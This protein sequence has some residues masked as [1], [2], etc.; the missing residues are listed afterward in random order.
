MEFVDRQYAKNTGYKHYW[1][2]DFIF[3]LCYKNF[4]DQVDLDEHWQLREVI[5]KVNRFVQEPVTEFLCKHYVKNLL[6]CFYPFLSKKIKFLPNWGLWWAQEN[7]LIYNKKYK[8]YIIDHFFAPT[9][10]SHLDP[11]ERNWWLQGR[12]RLYQGLNKNKK[13]TTCGQNITL[14]I[15]LSVYGRIV[16]GKNVLFL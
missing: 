12:G 14:K 5:K 16:S 2:E 6:E 1:E 7:G 13:V 9:R 15:D 4:L 8:K 11:P 3:D 10:W